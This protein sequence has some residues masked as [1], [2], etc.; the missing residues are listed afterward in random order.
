[1]QSAK[2]SRNSTLHVAQATKLAHEAWV[3]IVK[4]AAQDVGVITC[5]LHAFKVLQR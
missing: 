3:V 2:L 5:R 1:M 4:A